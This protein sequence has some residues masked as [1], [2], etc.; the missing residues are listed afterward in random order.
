MLKQSILTHYLRNDKK[1][2]GKFYN[3]LMI[4]L[5]ELEKAQ[6]GIIKQMLSVEKFS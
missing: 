5:N 1:N 3:D 4:T 2:L 6:Y